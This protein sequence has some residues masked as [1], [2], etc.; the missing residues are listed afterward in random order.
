MTTYGRPPHDPPPCNQQCWTWVGTGEATGWI[1]TDAST[2]CGHQPDP[3]TGRWKWNTRPNPTNHL[4]RQE[5][6]P[7]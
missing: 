3:T 2:R 4:P 5:N 1:Y 6:P 7:A